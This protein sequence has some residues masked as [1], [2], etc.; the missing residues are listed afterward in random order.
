MLLHTYMYMYLNKYSKS[1]LF[2]PYNATCVFSQFIN[3]QW[4]G[5]IFPGEVNFSFS[6]LLSVT[7]YLLSETG[8]SWYFLWKVWYINYYH[9]CSVHTTAV[10]LEK[11]YDILFSTIQSTMDAIK[12]SFWDV[13]IYISLH[14]GTTN[15]AIVQMTHSH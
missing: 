15:C 12:K 1:N 9:L 11:L 2:G 5:G 8:T 14:D 7:Y 6:Q 4:I 10:I 13:W 3:G